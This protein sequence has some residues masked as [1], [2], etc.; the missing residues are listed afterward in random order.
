MSWINYA[1]GGLRLDDTLIEIWYA[2][3]PINMT[4]EAGRRYEG[5]SRAFDVWL[6]W[7]VI[8]STETLG[9]AKELAVQLR[10]ALEEMGVPIT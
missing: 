4:E 1:P 9:E 8:Y 5:I 10:S 7:D 6:A 2:H 3:L